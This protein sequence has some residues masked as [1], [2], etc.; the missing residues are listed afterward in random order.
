MEQPTIAAKVT[1]F[2]QEQLLAKLTGFIEQVKKGDL[3][4]FEEDLSENWPRLLQPRSSRSTDSS[5]AGI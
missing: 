5:G 4:K 1:T 3:Y 2:I